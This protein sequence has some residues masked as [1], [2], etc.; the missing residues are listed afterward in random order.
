MTDTASI[1]PTAGGRSEAWRAW[2][3]LMANPF[4]LISVIGLGILLL[5]AL[6]AP[7]LAPYD[8]TAINLR[9][10][11]QPPSAAHWLGTDEI[12]RDM[13]SRLIYA[14]R[15]AVLVVVI[16]IGVS[17]VIGTLIGMIS[18]YVGGWVDSVIMRI[19]DGL[20]AFPTLIL[21]LGIV[22]ALGPSLWN[23]LIAIAIINV[24]NFARLARGEAM[25]LRKAEFVQASRAIGMPTWQILLGPIRRHLTATVLVYATLKASVAIITEAS[26]SFLGLGAQ[27]PTPTW[28]GMI[29]TGLAQMNRT[30]WLAFIP[31]MALFI[32][33]LLLNF[34]GDALRD[35]LDTKL[36]DREQAS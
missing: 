8:P 7:I 36:S 19:T 4:G 17:I 33:V 28:G 21:A 10:I 3:R 32:T 9:A 30:W 34:C 16:S 6:F 11:L 2:R 25:V 18:G 29:A 27:P 22:A 15:V 14:T 35:A 31:G 12:G 1:E 26:L 5:A 20:L 24:P 13:L 23:A